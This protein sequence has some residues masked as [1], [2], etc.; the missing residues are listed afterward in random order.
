MEISL[1][2]PLSFETDLQLKRFLM[3][4]QSG[5]TLVAQQ[6]YVTL[7]TVI[8]IRKDP[9]NALSHAHTPPRIQRL[10]GPSHTAACNL[11]NPARPSLSPA[12]TR[13]WDSAEGLD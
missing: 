8:M 1:P 11:P 3:V 10:L 12:R 5:S 6:F 4:K 2:F 9:H 13:V 7:T